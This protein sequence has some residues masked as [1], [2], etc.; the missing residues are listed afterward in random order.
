MSQLIVG[1]NSRDGARISPEQ[2]EMVRARLKELDRLLDLRYFPGVGNRSGRY[3]LIVR[4]ADADPRWAAYRSGDIGEPFD[5]LGWFTQAAGS[6]DFH[7]PC[8]VPVRPDDLLDKVIEFLRAKCDQQGVSGT[9]KDR[10][11]ASMEANKAQRERVRQ[12]AADEMFAGL[13]YGRKKV[14][15]EPIV[16]LG[17][18][19]PADPLESSDGGSPTIDVVSR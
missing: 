1:S 10:M 12:E 5:C 6:G 17:G 8:D 15:G 9:W 3:G 7:E 16:N 13:E 18:A 14:L 2:E 11:R 4:W 19:L